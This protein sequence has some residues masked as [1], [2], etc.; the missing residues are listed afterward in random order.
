[1]T[2]EP[3]KRLNVLLITADQWRG[4]SLS[5]LG[6][7]CAKTPTWTPWPPMAFASRGTMVRRRLAVRRG[8]RS[9]PAFT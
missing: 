5:M 4:D 1:M 3:G 6:H 9:I 7:P 2:I 8:P